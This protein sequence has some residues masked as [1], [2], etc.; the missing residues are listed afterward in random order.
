MSRRIQVIKCKCGSAFA[1]CIEPDCYSDK[2][3]QK[4]MRK[5]VKK[6]CTVDLIDGSSSEP[7]FQKCVCEKKKKKVVN[8]VN[9]LFPFI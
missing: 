4:D 5:Y 2:K 8:D 1:A 6:G 3:W 9:P 7:L